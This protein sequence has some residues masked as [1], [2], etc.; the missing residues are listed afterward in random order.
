[1]NKATTV[2]ATVVRVIADGIN[3]LYNWS[4]KAVDGFYHDF[5]LWTPDEYTWEYRRNRGE[6]ETVKL[7]DEEDVEIARFNTESR[8]LVITGAQSSA[9][10]YCEE[11]LSLTHIQRVIVK[12]PKMEQKWNPYLG[13][14]FVPLRYERILSDEI[15]NANILDPERY[16]WRTR[17][18]KTWLQGP[19]GKVICKISSDGAYYKYLKNDWEELSFTDENKFR[20]YIETMYSAGHKQA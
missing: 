15:E 4:L 13:K 10:Y 9:Q 8:I 3:T 20:D 7:L 11:V 12:Y 5:I 18:D 6:L 2:A 19:K 16:T 17:D 14:H 1:M